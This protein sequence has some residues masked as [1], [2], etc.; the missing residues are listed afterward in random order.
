M[1]IQIRNTDGKVDYI[2]TFVSN[3]KDTG[4]IP[5]FNLF[6]LFERAQTLQLIYPKVI[7]II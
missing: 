1:T 2:Q 5:V 4:P 7:G 6:G 3:A